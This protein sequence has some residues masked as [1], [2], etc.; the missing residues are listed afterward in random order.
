MKEILADEYPEA[1]V[2]LSSE[3]WPE[4]REYE[5]TV[6]TAVDAFVKPTMAAYVERAQKAVQ[7]LGNGSGSAPFLIMQSNGGVLSAPEV[8]RQPISTLLSGPAAGALGASW[9]AGLAGFPNA[10]TVDAGGTSTDIC[11]VEGGAPHVTTE[12]K[13]GRFPVKVPMIDIATIGTGG[14]SI[15]WID[16]SGG[17]RVGPRS[18]GADPGPMC[19]GKGGEE[20]TLTDAN[21][22]LGRLPPHLLGGQVPLD[23]ERA[24]RGLEGLARTLEE[25]GRSLDPIQLAAGVLEIADWNQVNAIRQVTVKKGLDPRDYT[26]VAFGGSGPLQAGRVAQLLD[27]QTVVVP[28]SPGN[29]SAFGLLAVDLRTEHVLTSVQRE[30]ALDLDRV[31]AAYRQLEEGAEAKLRQE[32]V[33]PDRRRYLRTA[34]VRYFGEAYEVRI[35]VPPEE[36]DPDGLHGVI[37]RFHTAHERLYGY[38]YRGTQL[39]EIVNLRVTAVGLIDKPRMA[40]APEGEPSSAVPA[41]ERPVVF[42]GRFISCPIYERERLAPG[43][44]V[45]GPGIVEE[46]GSTTVMQPGQS[47][48]VDRYGNLII[49]PEGP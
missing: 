5:R 43:M 1:S 29:V 28:P 23:L 2:S 49:S 32:G 27:L 44:T 10:L 21:L 8:A 36:L 6:T 9:L 4:Y 41:R 31:N 39:T 26:M 15:A 48:R 47:A 13:V 45:S 33:P 11:V 40:E 7:S 34:D 14:G 20:P 38:S 24:R 25:S 42:D 18:A 16:P 19:Y 37:D 17:L 22:L 35:E 12:G 46:Y 3:V 30:D